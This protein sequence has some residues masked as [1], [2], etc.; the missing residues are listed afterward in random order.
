MA[1]AVLGRTGLQVS[2]VGGGGIGQ[3]GGPTT[4]A[5]VLPQKFVAKNPCHDGLP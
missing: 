3:V 5:E 2:R 4:A 1:Y